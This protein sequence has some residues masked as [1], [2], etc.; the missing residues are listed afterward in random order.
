MWDLKYQLPSQYNMK[1]DKMTMAASLE[2]RTP[3][4]DNNIISWSTSIPSK[5][6]FNGSIDKYILRLAMR[7]I[8]P[9]VILR[10]KKM[11]FG[12]PVN[13]WLKKGLKEVSSGILERLEKRKLLKSKYIRSVK[14]NR[15]NHLYQDRAWNL[16]MFELWYETFFENDGLKPIRI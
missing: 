12:T 3:F 9:P 7:D 15:M 16:I 5:L 2:A 1:I 11:G 4:L 6:K 14:R 10:R 13:F 8:L